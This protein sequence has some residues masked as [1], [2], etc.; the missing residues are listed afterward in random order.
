[1][2]GGGRAEAGGGEGERARRVAELEGRVAALEGAA[3][4]LGGEGRGALALALAEALGQMPPGME[5]ALAAGG[6]SFLPGGEAGVGPGGVVGPGPGG[7]GHAAAAIP[8]R[9]AMEAWAAAAVTRFEES[10]GSRA[11]VAGGRRAAHT[12]PLGHEEGGGGEGRGEV[13]AGSAPAPPPS[14]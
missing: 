2:E 8:S 4:A 3:G 6:G 9:E 7:E 13:A 14:S 10:L 1:M 12:P 5:A 11:E